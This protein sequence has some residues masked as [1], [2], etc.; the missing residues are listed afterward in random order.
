MFRGFVAM[1]FTSLPLI[2]KI[3]ERRDAYWA[4]NTTRISDMLNGRFSITTNAV[5]C[6]STA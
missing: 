6:D 3:F 4:S 2:V 5:A 1:Q